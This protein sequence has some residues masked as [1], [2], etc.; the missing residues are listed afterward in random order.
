MHIYFS[1]IGGV[2]IGPL[3][4]VARAAGHQVSGSDLSESLTTKRLRDMGI[5]VMIGQ[6]GAEIA[7]AHA[8][9]PI[10]WLVYSAAITPE[11]PERVFA[12]DHNIRATMRDALIN[13]IL[14]EKNLKMIGIAGTH[15]KT[16]TTAMVVWL[17][18]ELN[19]PLSY[20]V[21]SNMSF[22]PA[23]DYTVDSQYF[24]YEADE[25][26]RNFLS[27]RPTLSLITTITYDHADIYPTEADYQAAFKQ[28]IDQSQ[29]A[30]LW[31]PDAAKLA[32]ET[33]EKIAILP[34]GVAEN[35]HITL[36]GLLNRAN[37]WLAVQATRELFPNESAERLIEI[38]NRFPGV[39]R[40]FEQIVPGLYSDYAHMP[41][42]IHAVIDLAREM[43]DNI[44]VVYQ[45]L[46]NTRQHKIR[47]DYK[48][49]FKGA[50]KVY[51]V[52]SYMAREDP[53]LP[54][55]SPEEL[56]TNLED[57]SIAEAA[58]MNDELE[59]AIRQELENGALVLAIAGG[60]SLDHWI[61][62]KFGQKS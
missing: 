44:V 40:R 46:H 51:W 45:G 11:N 48:D 36:P 28:F 2:G 62:E 4:M 24:V 33:N 52:P 53:N 17:L 56:I 14:E 58:N 10:D 9:K 38:I 41:Q 57:P 16:T 49:A 27:Y 23:G 18:H 3:A 19:Q 59:K 39:E 54:I 26:A 8:Q 50:G 34:S 22:G 37:A 5:E 25:F 13:Q 61:R 43:S 42:E 35:Q 1:G 7:A 29:K 30:I 12:T 31:Q 21:G 55:L 20:S 60:S 32:L 15:G 47:S 6:S